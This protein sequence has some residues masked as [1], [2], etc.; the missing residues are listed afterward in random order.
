MLF[1]IQVPSSKQ[2][3][4]SSETGLNVQCALQNSRAAHVSVASSFDVWLKWF[5]EHVGGSC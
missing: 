5:I 2:K 1:G 4:A 3:I